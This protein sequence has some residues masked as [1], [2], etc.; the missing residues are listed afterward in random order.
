VIGAVFM[1]RIPARQEAEETYVCVF[2]KRGLYQFG[3]LRIA[4]RFPFGLIERVLSH[5]EDGEILVLP[6]IVDVENVMRSARTELGEQEAHVKGRGMGLY[7]IREYRQGESARDI[8][9][10]VSARSG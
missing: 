8:H 10:K 5:V 1:T 4:T 6:A 7:G 3:K 9:W 2:P